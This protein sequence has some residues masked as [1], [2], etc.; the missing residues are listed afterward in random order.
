MRRIRKF[1]ARRGTWSRAVA[2]LLLAGC[3]PGAGCFSAAPAEA[4]PAPRTPPP[5]ATNAPP[6]AP[7]APA[8][9]PAPVKMPEP[10]PWSVSYTKDSARAIVDGVTVFLGKPSQPNTKTGVLQPSALDRRYTLAPLQRGRTTPLT[11]SRPIRIC[12][13]AGHGGQ[14]VGASSPDGRTHEKTITL[15]I[16]RRVERLLRKDGFEVLLTRRDNQTTQQLA[17]RP[18]KAYRWRADAFVSIHL[19]SS[20][21]T[22]ARGVETYVL[23]AL[24][25]ES[26]SY[27]ENKPSKESTLKYPGNASDVG[28][29]QLG[30]AIQRRLLGATGLEDRGL[31]RARFV[32][33]REASMPAALVECAF[34]TASKDLAFLRSEA[35]R[36]KIARGIYEG[37]ADWAYG[38]FAPGLPPHQP[39]TFGKRFFPK[40][41][42]AYTAAAPAPAPQGAAKAPVTIPAT[43]PRWQPA[44][45]PTDP[46]Y[47][48]ARRK[49]M[50]AAGIA[51]GNK[52]AE[53]H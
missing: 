41:P 29:V 22:S 37:I 44:P 12:L 13:D 3:L 31:R 53:T 50:E 23:P 46:R 8:P 48:A 47:E 42:P 52:P 28:N 4:V 40:T 5:A 18:F 34:L 24:G 7:A 33:L 6:A 20:P 10:K 30:F 49:A 17:E 43:F 1:L 36:D 32:V 19:N 26:S 14:D 21:A 38:T 9:E 16:A 45:A 51:P 25:M 39:G 2:L 35:G 15:D 11:T 27:H